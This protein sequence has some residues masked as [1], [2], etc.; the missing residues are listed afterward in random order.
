M[1]IAIWLAFEVYVR[2]GKG[3]IILILAFVTRD[4]PKGK[5]YEL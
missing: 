1:Y 2:I 3:E 4:P 5:R